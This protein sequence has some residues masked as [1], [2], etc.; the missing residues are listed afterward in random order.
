MNVYLPQMCTYINRKDNKFNV[1]AMV[2]HLGPLQVNIFTWCAIYLRTR[3][4]F[5]IIILPLSLQN[6][7]RDKFL[8][9]QV[10]ESLLDM[11]ILVPI[12]ISFRKAISV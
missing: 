10:Q 11:F 1:L 9:D 7:Y 6:I 5:N 2:F 12:Q 4:P 3:K 8:L